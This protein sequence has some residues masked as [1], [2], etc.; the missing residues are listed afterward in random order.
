MALW[1]KK[2]NLSTINLKNNYSVS[3]F[4]SQWIAAPAQES[5]YEYY[6]SNKKALLELDTMSK[7]VRLLLK[8]NP[9]T[10]TK[11]NLGLRENL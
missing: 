2:N 10:I 6:K 5:F 9:K 11:E 1:Y 4:L 3:K 8:Q 7:S